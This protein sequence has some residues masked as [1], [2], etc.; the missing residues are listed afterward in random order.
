L[1]VFRMLAEVKK[2]H[3]DL[4]RFTDDKGIAKRL[5][6]AVEIALRNAYY[7]ISTAENKKE[8]LKNYLISAFIDTR[9]FDRAKDKKECLR[10]AEKIAN[11]IL[12]VGGKDLMKFSEL[13]IKWNNVRGLI[14]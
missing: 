1:R 3:N 6:R 5:H 10:V 13:Y 12:K 7:E 9:A 4:P 8:V 2:L 11:E 14:Q